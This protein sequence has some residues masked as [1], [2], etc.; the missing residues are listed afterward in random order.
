M[1][2]LI[3]GVYLLIFIISGNDAV[4]QENPVVQDPAAGKILDRVA[5]K[6]KSGTSLQADFSLDIVDRKEDTRNTSKG[7]LVMKQNKYLL[8]TQGSIVYFDG[9]NMWT[10]VVARN[11]VTVTEPDN[12]NPDFLSNPSS[13][14]DTYNATFKYKLV[15]QTTRNGIA[16]HEIDLFPKN[17]NQPYSRIKVFVNTATDLPVAISSVGKDGVDYT[18]TL[19]NMVTGKE[20]PDSTFVFDAEKNKKVEVIDMR[21]L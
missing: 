9:S 17:L 20:Y 8:H 14:F 6:L 15:R 10:H 7:S 1:Q 19:S 3:T 16:C 2:K 21:G 4:S 5:A 18:V 13:F 11:E 12:D